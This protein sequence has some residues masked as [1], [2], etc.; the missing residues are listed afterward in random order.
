MSK[1][2]G[3]KACPVILYVRVSTEEQATSGLSI[4]DQTAKLSA[5]PLSRVGP[6]PS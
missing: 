6:T 2:T 5:M 4:E 3:I 1:Q